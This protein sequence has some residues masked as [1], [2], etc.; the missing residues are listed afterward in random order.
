MTVHQVCVCNRT[1]CPNNIQF[2]PNQS[3]P[4]IA[5]QFNNKPLT[6]LI[7][8]GA[9]VPLIDE[10]YCKS[11]SSNESSSQVKFSTKTVQ[12]I[13]C[14][15][16]QLQISG[17][18]TGK[19]QFHQYDEPPL[20]AEFYILKKCSQQCI[21]PFTWLKALKVII[22]LN[23]LSLQYEHPSEE[24]WLLSA[25]GNLSQERLHEPEFWSGEASDHH[26]HFVDVDLKPKDNH[27]DDP[28][29]Q[30]D[31]QNDDKDPLC[32]ED[33]G[34]D[35]DEDDNHHAFSHTDD[36]GN[37][38]GHTDDV[39]NDNETSTN[40]SQIPFNL[41]SLTIQPKSSLSRLLTQRDPP[42]LLA[43]RKHPQDFIITM[44]FFLSP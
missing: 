5:V 29:N 34:D 24:G 16:T 28:D 15:G 33:D 22:D 14:D 36:V 2:L 19:F 41:P 44:N 23:T 25:E 37:D 8:T 30:H 17:T 10:Q 42:C 20:F 27:D 21:F 18:I 26:H 4:H 7:D 35:D 32:I 3:L 38:D 6:V 31:D 11:F 40:V 43:S 39:G 12:A 1:P 9:Q 13:G